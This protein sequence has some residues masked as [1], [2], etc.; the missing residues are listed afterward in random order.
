MA[1]IYWWP[2][3]LGCPQ[4]SGYNEATQTTSVI[5]TTMQ[6]GPQKFR[7]RNSSSPR[8]I[9]MQLVLRGAGKQ[10]LEG[11]YWT[12][13][14][15]VGSFYMP[16]YSKP[17]YQDNVAVYRFTDPPSFDAIGPKL[18]SAKLMLERLTTVNGHFLLNIRE[19]DNLL[20]T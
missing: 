19:E 20:S 15:E 14:N 13:L 8:Q 4:Q 12:T 9:T 18:W 17:L 7:R 2:R 10:T 6:A 16:D 1:E 11:F 5:K 3:S